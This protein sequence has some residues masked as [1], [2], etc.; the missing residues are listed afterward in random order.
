MNENS[1]NLLLGNGFNK[2]NEINTGYVNIIKSLR[3]YNHIGD[4]LTD[5][6][7]KQADEKVE[8]V[9]CGENDIHLLW[10]RGPCVICGFCVICAFCM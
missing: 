8:K 4:I 7:L 6:V 2:N 3:K 1:K 10:K 5:H 9:I